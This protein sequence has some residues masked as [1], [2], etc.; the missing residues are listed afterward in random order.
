MHTSTNT[1]ALQITGY[2]YSVDEDA[3]AEDSAESVWSLV[4]TSEGGKPVVIA[5]VCGDYA[6]HLTQLDTTQPQLFVITI[7]KARQ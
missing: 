1:P 5:G 7:Q 4:F 6:S 2:L 3:T